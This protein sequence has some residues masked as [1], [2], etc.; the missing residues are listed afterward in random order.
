M[1]AGLGKELH[2]ETQ[3]G[4]GSVFAFFGVLLLSTSTSKS[5]N[6]GR[7]HLDPADGQGASLEGVKELQ[8]KF[9]EGPRLGEWTDTGAISTFTKRK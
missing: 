2:C 5:R 6:R 9:Q 8:V 3:K 1:A 7:G 4:T